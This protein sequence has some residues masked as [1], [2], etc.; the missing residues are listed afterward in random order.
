VATFRFLSGTPSSFRSS[1]HGTRTFC[2]HCG[3]PL[4]FRSAHFPDEIDVTNL[5][6]CAARPPTPQGS[7]PHKFE[8]AVGRTR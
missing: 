8:V 2:P 7:H 4:T 6:P 1:D 5:L 3:T